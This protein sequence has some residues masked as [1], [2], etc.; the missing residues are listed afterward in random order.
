MATNRVIAKSLNTLDIKDYYHRTQSDSVVMA[1]KGGASGALLTSMMSVAESRLSEVE[2]KSGLRKRVFSILVEMLQNIYHHF[3]N[4]D[5]T[6]LA[7]DDSIVFVVWKD[8]S[9]YVLVTGNYIL[10]NDVPNL[11][12]RI[13]E[14]NALNAEELKA[15]YREV[16]DNGDISAKGGAGLGIIDIARK[17]GG[18]LDYEFKPCNDK[19]SFFSLTVKISAIS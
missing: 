6:Q 11:Q 16:L 4:I 18:K 5:A 15:K 10:A 12:R 9:A 1:Y 13:D 14:T 3:G 19:Y 2:P 7:A 8:E 17:S